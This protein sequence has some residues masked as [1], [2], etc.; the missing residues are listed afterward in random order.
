MFF[1]LHVWEIEGKLLITFLTMPY[2]GT[3]ATLLNLALPV[4]TISGL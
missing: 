4:S 1:T 3:S 2:R